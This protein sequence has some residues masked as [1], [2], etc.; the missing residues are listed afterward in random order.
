MVVLHFPRLRKEL[1]ALARN[2]MSVARPL[3]NHKSETKLGL[4]EVAPTE[5]AKS[6]KLVAA[7]S[8][9]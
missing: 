4:H 1:N 6:S 3:M 5:M 7:S 2:N 8:P 9:R